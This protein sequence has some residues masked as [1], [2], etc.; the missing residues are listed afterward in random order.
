MPADDPAPEVPLTPGERR[1]V[2]ALLHELRVRALR[3]R[4]LWLFGSR[5]RGE[6]EER[7]DLDLA[8]ELGGG[9]DP[10]RLAEAALLGSELAVRFRLPLELLVLFETE[11]GTEFRRTLQREGIL[12]WRQEKETANSS[13]VC[14]AA[15]GPG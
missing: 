8:V 15:S 11:E 14:D 6:A 2:T 7:S 5:L 3:P 1:L 12:L 4:R 10:G 13:D 9:R